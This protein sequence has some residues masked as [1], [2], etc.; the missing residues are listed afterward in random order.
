MIVTCTCFAGLPL[1]LRMI[2]Y[3]AMPDIGPALYPYRP[4]SPHSP[5]PLWAKLL[6]PPQPRAI[7]FPR[8]KWCNVFLH[9]NL[10]LVRFPLPVLAQVCREAR[11]AVLN[12]A[13]NIG[14]QWVPIMISCMWQWIRS[15]A[16]IAMER[17]V[18]PVD[19]LKTNLIGSITPPTCACAVW[20]FLG[21]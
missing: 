1:E 16:F 10:N 6:V 20:P 13:A 15:R 8:H 14:V 11:R 12:W 17:Q 21:G 3:A 5:R 4:S 7:Y 18:I 9:Q 19:I 2:W